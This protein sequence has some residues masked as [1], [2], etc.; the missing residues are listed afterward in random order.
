[1]IERIIGNIETVGDTLL[2]CIGSLHGNESAGY[3]GLKE[4]FAQIDKFNIDIKGQFTAILGNREAYKQNKRYLDKD[5]NR[6]WTEN[7]VNNAVLK[8]D[9]S[10]SEYQEVREILEIVDQFDTKKYKRIVFMD[11][12]TTSS[13]NGVFLVASLDLDKNLLESL[14]SPIIYGLN[15]ALGGTAIQYFKKRGYEAFVFEGGTIGDEQ[16]VF[17]M[18]DAIWKILVQL[19]M[20]NPKD[21]PAG[22]CEHSKLGYLIENNIP[23]NLH[24]SYIHHISAWEEYQTVPSL[25]N[26]NWVDEGDILAHNRNGSVK[27]PQSGYLLMPLYQSEG[28]DGYFIVND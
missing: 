1:M 28:D 16:A 14:K 18:V 3:K 12:H 9:K 2:F 21:V 19:E 8:N 4:V 7:R 11:L 25:S 5:L 10:I 26:F 27:S 20:V 22:V 15:E 6:A 23:Q 24:L 13:R 17:N